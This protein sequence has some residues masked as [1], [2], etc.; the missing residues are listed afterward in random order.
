M[1]VVVA[2]AAVVEVS[3]VSAASSKLVC[4]SAADSSV[5][6]TPGAVT[7]S[8]S[9]SVVALLSH[10]SAQGITGLDTM[11]LSRS[12]VLRDTFTNGLA[13][14]A[15]LSRVTRFAPL[16]RLTWLPRVHASLATF[17]VEPLVLI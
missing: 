6:A 7:I 9:V 17:P 1:F 8:S 10:V 16:S 5:S 14:F 12:G 4:G 3:I 15:V 13:V 2:G 11:R